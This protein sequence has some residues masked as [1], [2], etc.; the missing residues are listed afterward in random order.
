MRRPLDEFVGEE[1]G[2][3][4]AW[5]LLSAR[6]GAARKSRLVGVARLR[7]AY[8]R[9]CLQDVHDPHNIG[10]CLRSAEANGLQNVDFVNIFQKFAKT[11]STT[12]RG[13]NHWL[14]LSR[15]TQQKLYIEGLRARGYKIAAAYPSDNAYQLET[16]P[17]D[18]PLAIL[19]GNENAGLDESWDQHIDYKFSIP[20]YGMTESYNVS[21]SAALILYSLTQ[22]TRL[23][24]DPAR[25]LLSEEDQKAV[26]NRWMARHSRNLEKE[27]AVL[28]R[29][30]KTNEQSL[31]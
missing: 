22:R 27:L 20:M 2:I 25:L 9:L 6:L 29:S 4:D 21:V 3:T 10:A 14:D 1:K 31:S 19:L 8:I 28:R 5:D 24:I 13:A 15:F 12:S 26:L 18:Q 17:I 16:L 23:Q 30:V 7:S 11:S